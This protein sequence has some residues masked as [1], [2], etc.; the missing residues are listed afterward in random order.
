MKLSS[1]LNKSYYVSN[2]YIDSLE[3]LQVLERYILHNLPVL[4]IFKKIIVATTY[5]TQDSKLIEANKK[6]WLKFFP[7][8]VQI[9]LPVN[10]GHGFGIADS[11]NALIEYCKNQKAK[12]VCKASND[13][14]LDKKILNKEVGKSDFYY[15]NGISFEDLYKNNFNNVE[16]FNNHFFPQTNFYIIRVDKIDYLYDKDYVNETYEYMLTIPNYNNK[17]WEYIPGWACEIFL[18][19]CVER[20]GLSKEYLLDLDKHNKL[21]NTIKS[22]KIG[23]PSHKNIMVEGICHYQFLDQNILEI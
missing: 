10:R 18:K 22:Y 9:D 8:S 16:L 15:L 13:L 1:I 21:C 4:S 11:E 14:I 3:S 20:N 19:N 17:I 6:L 12:W 23:D 2:G 7:T 5:K